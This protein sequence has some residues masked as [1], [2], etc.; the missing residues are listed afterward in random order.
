M[1]KDGPSLKNA[2]LSKKGN[3]L[4]YVYGYIMVIKWRQKKEIG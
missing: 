2:R 4:Q 1:T 3:I